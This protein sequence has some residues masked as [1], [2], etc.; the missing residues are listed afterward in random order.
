[1]DADFVIYLGDVITADN[2]PI[3]NASLY[4]DQAL[5]PT[6]DRCIPW[7]SVFGNHDDAHFVWPTEWFSDSGIPPLKCS[8]VSSPSSGDQSFKDMSILFFDLLTTLL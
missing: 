8:S 7:A 4:W 3:Q 5:A 1:M 2:I 6:K